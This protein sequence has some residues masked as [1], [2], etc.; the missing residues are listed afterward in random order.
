MIRRIEEALKGLQSRLREATENSR[1]LSG[2]DDSVGVAMIRVSEDR[3]DLSTANK[4]FCQLVEEPNLD[5]LLNRN[6]NDFMPYTIAKVH[7][8]CIVHQK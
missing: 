7:D 6:L 5:N 1:F 4:A 8:K 2:I 3:I